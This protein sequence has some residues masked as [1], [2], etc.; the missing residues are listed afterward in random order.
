MYKYS[1]DVGLYKRKV[2]ENLFKASTIFFLINNSTSART[3]QHT[4]IAMSTQTL[5]RTIGLRGIISSHNVDMDTKRIKVETPQSV[6]II[7]NEPIV[8]PMPVFATSTQRET[9]TFAKSLLANN[10]APS[11]SSKNCSS[12][13]PV[14]A[15]D[16]R[17]DI[18][19]T[20][21]SVATSSRYSP[22][23]LESLMVNANKQQLE[24]LNAV[25]EG[26]NVFVTGGAGVGKSY[27]IKLIKTSLADKVNE[28]EH[29]FIDCF[30][31]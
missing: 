26:K 16:N 2:Y 17:I 30:C 12:K 3:T 13:I 21:G 22:D 25:M 20:R 27:F 9:N 6:I 23:E 31:F 24:A 1:K 29:S 28:R 5:Q 15:M 11:L 19:K 14:V 10:E 8:H 18:P 4:Q 7:K